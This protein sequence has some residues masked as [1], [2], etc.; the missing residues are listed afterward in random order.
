VAVPCNEKGVYA[1]KAIGVVQERR[2]QGI[3]TALYRQIRQEVRKRGADTLRIRT[4]SAQGFFRKMAGKEFSLE[5]HESVSVHRAR[6]KGKDL[7][8][9]SWFRDPVHT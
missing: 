3:G 5:A 6:Y 7:I 8:Q 9:V 4:L 2:G 1:L